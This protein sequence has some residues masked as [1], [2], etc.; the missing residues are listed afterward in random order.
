MTW[1]GGGFEIQ[2]ESRLVGEFN[3]DNLLAAIAPDARHDGPGRRGDPGRGW[4]P[5]P[6]CP[7][8][9]EVIDLGQDFTAMV[10]FAHTPNALRRALEAARRMTGGRVIAVFGSA[11]L[12]DREKR[13]MMAETSAELADLTVLTAEDPRTEPLEAILGRWRRVRSAGGVEGRS[14]LARARPRPGA[15]LC[16]A[17]GTAGRPGDRLRQGARAVDVLWRDGVSLG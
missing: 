13:R 12:R 17:A 3:V 6:G 16:G 15:A 4:Q 2:V 9:M 5:C 14:F 11:G 1:R 7:G 8:R 10:D